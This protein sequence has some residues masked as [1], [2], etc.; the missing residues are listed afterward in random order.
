MEKE[1]FAK[2][3]GLLIGTGLAVG[4]AAVLLTYLGSARSSAIHFLVQV[5]FPVICVSSHL[6][7]IESVFEMA[8][9]TM[10]K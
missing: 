9:C 6:H 3:Y 1:N 10:Y 2:R 5:C 8:F 4:A 7:S